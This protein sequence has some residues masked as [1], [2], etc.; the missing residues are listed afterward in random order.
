MIQRIQSLY[1][2]IVVFLSTMMLYGHIV[3]FVGEEGAIHEIRYNG[4]YAMTGGAGVK[5]E[6]LLPLTALLLIIPLLAF[7]SLLLFKRRRLQIRTSV[8][9]LLLLLGSVVI[10]GYF[11]FYVYTKFDARVIFNIKIVFPVISSILMYLAFRGIL[12]DELLVRSYDRL[13]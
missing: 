13:R 8:L 10:V 5:I 3:S 6:P 11:I 7:I 4:L 1:I 9:T 2:S 12:K